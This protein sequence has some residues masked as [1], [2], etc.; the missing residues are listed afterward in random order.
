MATIITTDLLRT[1]VN[2]TRMLCMLWIIECKFKHTGSIKRSRRRLVSVPWPTCSAVTA[3]A[4]NTA[5]WGGG[6]QATG[7]A[8]RPPQ[9]Q[10][11]TLLKRNITYINRGSPEVC[12]SFL[13]S[14]MRSPHVCSG[15]S[16]ATRCGGVWSRCVT[17]SVPARFFMY[18]FFFF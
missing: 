10:E 2:N 3:A 18:F 6:S 8:E 9:E 14:G 16:G 4:L 17:P 12:S 1:A 15:P 13:G 11:V 5:C 7:R